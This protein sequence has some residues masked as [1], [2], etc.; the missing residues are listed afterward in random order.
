MRKSTV[1]I[2]FKAWHFKIHVHKFY[3]LC[4]GP[5]RAI[6]GVFRGRLANQEEISYFWE[7]PPTLDL[8]GVEPDIVYCVE[9]YN[10]TCEA[11]NLIATECELTNPVYPASVGEGLNPNFV[12]N[13]T[14]V[15]RSNVPGAANGAVFTKQGNL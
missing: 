10:I 3:G 7:P 1:M 9:V 2:L 12:Y 13:I 6:S 5:L 15:P 11:D 4:L 14:V 8:T